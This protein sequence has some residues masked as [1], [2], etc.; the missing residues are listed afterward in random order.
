M[1]GFE[2]EVR[3]END[4]SLVSGMFV[5]C[6]QSEILTQIP[7]L[8]RKWQVGIA[9]LNIYQNKLWAV[10]SVWTMMFKLARPEEN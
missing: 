7:P 1:Q 3:S 2:W 9:Y 8:L 10:L 5:T 4:C 6:V